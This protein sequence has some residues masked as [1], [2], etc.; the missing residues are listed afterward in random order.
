MKER[1]T[2]CFIAAAEPETTGETLCLDLRVLA[3]PVVAV[4]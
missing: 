1:P 3:V 2:P 4:V